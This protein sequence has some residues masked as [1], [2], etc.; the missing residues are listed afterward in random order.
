M[1][2][3]PFHWVDVFADKPF[4]GSPAAVC[5]IEN[6]L[7]DDILLSIAAELNL[8]ETA[9]PSKIKQ[10][11]YRLRWFTPIR[12][13]PIC[14][15]ATIASAY[16]LVSEYNETSPVVFHTMSG[17]LRAEVEDS[18]VSLSFPRFETVREVNDALLEKHGITDYL[19]MRKLSRLP[20]IYMVE[21]DDPA[22]V[23]TLTPDMGSVQSVLRESG[24]YFVVVTAE[25]FRS[26]D[27][28][29]R[30]FNQMD[31][32]HGCVTGNA[33]IAGYWSMKLGKSRLV[34][35]QPTHRMTEM[36]VDV[37]DD[38]LMITGSATQVIK[39]TLTF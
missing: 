32:D 23:Q 25:G 29:F 6:E 27:Y 26:Y 7:E 34:S 24:A 15:H 16:T 33:L 9:Y 4:R 21:I 8:R 2:D 19:E 20:L 5:I 31:E 28:V 13:V 14:G 22:M 36:I 35:H 39:G 30:V 10:S 37:L 17:E 11:E 12:E 18:K 38:R 1:V 3:I